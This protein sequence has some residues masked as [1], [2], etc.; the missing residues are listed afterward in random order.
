MFLCFLEA[1][2][3]A[4][5]SELS[6]ARSGR[7][8]IIDGQCSDIEDNG[9]GSCSNVTDY[10]TPC[11]SGSSPLVVQC[12]RG[13]AATERLEKIRFSSNYFYEE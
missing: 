9:Y 1:S 11:G 12:A 10:D 7:S 2:I 3:V 13:I 6:T 5:D 4:Y 8:L